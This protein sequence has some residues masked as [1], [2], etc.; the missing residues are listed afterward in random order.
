MG[1]L[2]RDYG[3]YII[4]VCIIATI[5]IPDANECGHTILTDESVEFCTD[6]LGSYTCQCN[7][8]FALAFNGLTCGGNYTDDKVLFF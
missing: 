8:E 2:L 6:T 5:T 7:E 1:P 3:T 4:S